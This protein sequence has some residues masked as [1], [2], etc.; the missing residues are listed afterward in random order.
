MNIEFFTD[1]DVALEYYPPLP[2]SQML[3]EWYKD[4]PRWYKPPSEFNAREVHALKNTI[5]QT[6]KACLPVMD[7]LT[8]G[9]V[10]R[11]PSDVMITPEE[12]GDTKGYW[13]SSQA[14][15]CTSHA[16]QQCP[17]DIGGHK[18]EYIKLL[19]KWGVR[20]PTGYSTFFYQPDFLFNNRLKLFP[21]VVDT[22]RYNIPVSFPGTVLGDDTFIIKAG[23]PLMVAFPFKR[24]DWMHSVYHK[25]KQPQNII[26]R[27]FARGYQML[28]HAPKRYR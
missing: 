3:P 23:D 18:Y 21:A 20:T 6:I 12:H 25:E 27:V 17:V 24:E 1:D 4:L 11:S 22:D 16:H 19:N 14:L 15:A 8:S 10:I 13:W 28:F 26:H 7:Y 5:P 2:A 9:Y